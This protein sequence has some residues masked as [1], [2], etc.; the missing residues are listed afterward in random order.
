MG[1][2]APIYK[3][4]FDDVDQDAEKAADDIVARGIDGLITASNVPCVAIVKALIRRGVHIQKDIRIVGFDY[5]NIYD[6]FDPP[7]TYILQ[8]LKEISGEAAEYLFRLIDMQEK[9]EDIRPVKDKIILK[10]TLH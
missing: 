1:D 9:G 8:P 4:A 3:F 5:S 7:V 10:A 6:V 2:D